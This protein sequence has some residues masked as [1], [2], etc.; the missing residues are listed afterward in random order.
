MENQQRLKQVFDDVRSGIRSDPQ[1]DPAIF[2][3]VVQVSWSRA[4]RPD[5]GNCLQLGRLSH[6]LRDEADQVKQVSNLLIFLLMGTFSLFILT[7]YLIVF[8]RTITSIAECRS[9]G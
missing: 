6:L 9:M 7:S 8:R 4:C 2:L 5:P 3:A 1:G